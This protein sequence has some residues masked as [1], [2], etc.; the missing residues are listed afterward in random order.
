MRRQIGHAHYSYRFLENKFVALWEARGMNPRLVQM[1]ESIK[2]PGA[3]LAVAGP[4]EG[5]VVHVAFRST[6]NF[7][8]VPDV[9]NIAYFAWEF[10]V[11]KDTNLPHESILQNQVRMLNLAD[12]VWVPSTYSR[13]SLIRNGVPRVHV[14]PPPICGSTGSERLSFEDARALLAEVPCVPLTVTTG[15]GIEPM[16]IFT[17][18]AI[19]SIGAQSAVADRTGRIFLLICNPG[20]AR[21]NLLN[22]IEGFLLGAGPTDLFIV[23]LLV[24]NEGDYL[25]RG[26]PDRFVQRY[27]GPAAKYDPRVVFIFDYV[28]DEQ[29][30]A[31]Y[32]IADFYLSV[33]HCEGSNLPLLEAMACGTVPVS[34]RNTAM[35]DY[36]D[37]SAAVLVDEERYV[38]L[39]R[40][41][42]DVA[43]RVHA[44]HASTRFDVGR[45]VRAARNLTGEAYASMALAARRNVASMFSMAAVD[46]CARARLTALTNVERA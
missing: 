16:C 34:N 43:G 18:A 10:D 45:A 3:L 31:L 14:V 29:M 28:S 36:V 38:G 42:G 9:V 33:P 40:T 12:E 37:G 22:S 7:R 5:R 39:T 8:L 15:V 32:S 2:H 24:P 41:A 6:E 35:L 44:I 11:L 23:K 1:P 19:S 26:I 46:A 20:D 25:V 27:F 21:K 13:D 17:E 30:K 4:D